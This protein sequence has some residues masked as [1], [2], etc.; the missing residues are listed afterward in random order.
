MVS[1][2]KCT[3]CYNKLVFLVML[4]TIP[5]FTD[6]D[7][8]FSRN[9]LH[10]W[11]IILLPIYFFLLV[12]IGKRYYTKKFPQR[13]DKKLFVNG[14]KIKMLGSI[15]ITLIYNVYYSGGDTTGYFNDGR[16]LDRLLLYDPVT[17]IRMFFVSGGYN[18]WP[19][20]LLSISSNFRMAPAASTWIMAK[21][22][23]FFSLFCFQ[24]MLC[25]SLFFGFISYLCVW[26]FYI[27]LTKMYPQL[28]RK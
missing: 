6:D 28:K 3:L 12:K 17:A 24:S 7:L 21:M 13:T 10:W 25:T 2:Y 15:F 22:S 26:K 23:G 14:L 20:D 1:M 18:S 5:A 9:L 16:L 4:L 27:T 8:N 19:D 11:E